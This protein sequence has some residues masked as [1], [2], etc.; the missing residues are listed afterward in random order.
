MK[1]HPNKLYLYE[2]RKR[3]IWQL[4]YEGYSGPD[5]SQMMNGLDRGWI[6]RII[7][8][9]PPGWEPKIEKTPKTAVASSE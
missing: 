8:K 2:R 6:T 4:H 7:K 3:M 9:M 1:I 5:I